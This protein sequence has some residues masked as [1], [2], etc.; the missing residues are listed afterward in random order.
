MN[1]KR[2]LL[3]DPAAYQGNP[4]AVFEEIRDR[5]VTSSG[6]CADAPA[7]VKEVLRGT[8]LEP[9]DGNGAP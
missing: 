4:R 2:A 5:M 9:E 1:A 8:K 3:D 6:K 7:C